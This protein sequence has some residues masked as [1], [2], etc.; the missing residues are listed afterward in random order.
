MNEPNSL[1]A[2]DMEYCPGLRHLDLAPVDEK[3]K[4]LVVLG[5]QKAGTSWLHTALKQ[6]PVFV[7]SNHAFR[8]VPSKYYACM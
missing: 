7:E 6:H 3:F 8:Y 4:F 1:V 2:E 5:A